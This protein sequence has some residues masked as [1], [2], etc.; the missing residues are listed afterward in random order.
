MEFMKS[1]MIVIATLRNIRAPPKSRL[2][3]SYAM[4]DLPS[5]VKADNYEE[6]P[7]T[8]TNSKLVNID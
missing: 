4:F 2:L 6:S 3:W 5:P 7:S 8:K 1:T